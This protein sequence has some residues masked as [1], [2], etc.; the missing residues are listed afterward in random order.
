MTEPASSSKGKKRQG[1]ATETADTDSASQETDTR[2]TPHVTVRTSSSTLPVPL[3]ATQPSDGK[4]TSLKTPSD[5]YKGTSK[6]KAAAQSWTEGFTL[7]NPV[8]SG[9]AVPDDS[10]SALSTDTIDTAS[11]FTFVYGHGKFQRMILFCSLAA[12][13]SLLCHNLSYAMTTPYIDHWCSPSEEFSHLSAA[14][15]KNIAIPWKGGTYSQ[16]K[17]YDPPLTI[18]SMNRTQVDCQAWDFDTSSEGNSIVSQWSLVCHRK[19]LASWAAI[20]YM[21]GAIMALPVMGQL[22]DRIGRRP[23]ICLAVFVL[24]SAGMA[25]CFASTFLTFVLLRFLVG[26][27][28]STLQIATYVLLFEVSTPAHRCLH[29]VLV[30]SVTLT[31]VPLY[32]A[33]LELFIHKWVFIQ[34]GIM[35]P[36]ALL[37]CCFFIVVE[38]PRWLLTKCEAKRAE[39]VML[40]AAKLNGVDVSSTV[41]R[42]QRLTAADANRKDDI[43]CGNFLD[44]LKSPIFRRRCAA[45]FSCWFAVILA[46]YELVLGGYSRYSISIRVAAVLVHV[47]GYVLVYQ[48]M[49]KHGRRPTLAGLLLLFA[50]LL[51]GFT[52]ATEFPESRI[53]FVM[54]AQCILDWAICLVY[55]YSVE[56]FPTVVRSV[57]VCAAYFCGRLGAM[58]APLIKDIGDVTDPAISIGV[59]SALA[60]LGAVSVLHLPETQ[61][62]WIVDTLKQAE[63]SDYA[64]RKL[65]RMSKAILKKKK[66]PEVTV[67]Q[68][69]RP[70]KGLIL[71]PDITRLTDIFSGTPSSTRGDSG[72]LPKPSTDSSGRRDNRVTDG[73]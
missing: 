6:K 3:P 37:V 45:L 9:K 15:W 50:A 18:F 32:L 30:L 7:G 12:Q 43:I 64:S 21:S 10:P 70:V 67:Y 56:L 63:A 71:P 57:G 40:W 1:S 53:G 61:S 54:A 68:S 58:I 35:I 11:D 27:S 38:S 62:L 8:N 5:S 4:S 42:L 16:C 46:Y 60:M 66:V 52:M 29:C 55:V 25:V 20:V 22:A 33:V 41:Q 23:V 34:V 17:Q 31:T 59:I 13:F 47:A 28:A 69:Q 36:T 72:E 48:S 51:V 49:C 44:L 73:R 2:A 24:L 19:Y 65:P 26:A 14:D 39:K